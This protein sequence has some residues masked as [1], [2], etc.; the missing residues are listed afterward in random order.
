M[1]VEDLL[2]YVEEKL[3]YKFG[4]VMFR[5]PRAVLPDGDGPYTSIIEQQGF[6]PE[7]TH[8]AAGNRLP[9]YVRPSA[10]LLTRATKY[11]EAR[12]RA[13]QLWDLFQPV[14]DQLINGTW[15]RGLNVQGEV[16]DLTP[17]ERGR[18]RVAFN[19]DAIKR[20]SPAT[21]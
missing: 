14:H 1:F 11:G 17:D 9:A 18:V 15:W 5:G 21:S 2:F 4:T 12:S 20:P 8:N 19:I 3:G 13:Q 6:S 7:G 10:Q 16:F